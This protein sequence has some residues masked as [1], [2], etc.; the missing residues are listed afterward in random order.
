MRLQPLRFPV[1][2]LLC[3]AL[4][5]GQAFGAAAETT[6]PATVPAATATA[7]VDQPAEKKD[8]KK[9]KLL[10]PAVPV[11]AYSR[12]TSALFGV[13]MVRALRWKDAAPE[14]RPNTLALSGFYSLEKQW[15]LGLATSTYLHGEDYLVKAQI[16]RHR[17]PARFWGVG[18]EDGQHGEREDFTATGTGVTFGT[19]KKVY[20]AL[21]VGAGVWYG[22]AKIPIKEAGGLLERAAV[23]GSDGGT[24]IGVELQAEWDDRDNIYAPTAGTFVQ[25][26]AGLHRDYLGSDFDYEDYMLD[27]RKFISLGKGQVLAL[28][29]KGRIMG[30]DPPF[31]RLSSIG[32]I[33]VMRGLFDGRFRDKSMGAVQAEYRFPLWKSLGGAVFGGAGEVADIPADF[34]IRNIQFTGGLGLRLTLDPKERI[35]LRLDVGFSRY[36]TFPIV[37]ITEAF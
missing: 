13:M 18:T 10:L 28:Q 35:N 34:T 15:A 26:W 23:T 22:S 31:Y 36:G 32:G 25:F 3:G 20:R 24:D 6:A 30:G 12:E 37:V 2:A 16:Y 27:V 33:S 1:A 17:T 7:P 29:A 4:V 9:D 14:T 19:T 21:R 8:E 11:I 5:A